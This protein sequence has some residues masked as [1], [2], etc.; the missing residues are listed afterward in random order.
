MSAAIRR[1]SHNRRTKE[2]TA[3]KKTTSF[4][5]KC[6]VGF[7]TRYYKSAGMKKKKKNGNETMTQTCSHYGLTSHCRKSVEKSYQIR[8]FYKFSYSVLV[9]SI[10]MLLLLLLYKLCTIYNIFMCIN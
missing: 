2:R 10:Y 5:L 1:V 8:S 4:S 3:A 9:Y 7:A 6:L